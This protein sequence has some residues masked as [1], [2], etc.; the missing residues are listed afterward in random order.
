MIIGEHWRGG[1]GIINSSG[2]AAA[3]P[4]LKREGM[5][6]VVHHEHL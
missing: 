6:V 2:G 1:G 5:K 3:D 4:S